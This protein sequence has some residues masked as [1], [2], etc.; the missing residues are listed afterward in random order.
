MSSVNSLA[1]SW[2][3][4]DLIFDL[5]VFSNG[6]FRKLN[7]W[8]EFFSLL[9]FL[10]NFADKLVHNANK[11]AHLD[12]HSR[13]DNT[14]AVSDQ[15]INH[16][17]DMILQRLEAGLFRHAIVHIWIQ[18]VALSAA[19]AWTRVI[20]FNSPQKLLLVVGLT[21]DLLVAMLNVVGSCPHVDCQTANRLVV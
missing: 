14:G 2:P 16:W 9:C 6:I 21:G 5:L 10:L 12:Q 1:I 19:N 7:L 13:Q 20:L 17:V 15:H 3:A 18:I 4:S 11:E 8:F